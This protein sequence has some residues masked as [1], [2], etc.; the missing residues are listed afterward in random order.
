M[1][2]EALKDEFLTTE[3]LA[4]LLKIPKLTVYKWVSQRKIPY[5]KVGKHLRFKRSEI[6]EWLKERRVSEF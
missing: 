3:E 6:E 5:V 2:T 1:Q 4:T